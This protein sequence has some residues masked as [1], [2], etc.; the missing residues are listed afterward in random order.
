[1]QGVQ[2]LSL[3]VRRASAYRKSWANVEVGVPDNYTIVAKNT[4][5]SI[6][7]YGHV[8]MF[9]RTNVSTNVV[10]IY[11]MAYFCICSFVVFC[12]C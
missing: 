9:T 12:V 6:Y 7:I 5:I 10:A 1:M 11:F 3:L 2:L 8:G 4:C